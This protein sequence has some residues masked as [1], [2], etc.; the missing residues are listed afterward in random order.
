MNFDNLFS[1]FR[2]SV[3]KYATIVWLLIIPQLS[4]IIILQMV[5]IY[6][7]WDITPRSLSKVKTDVSEEHA[8]SILRVE[9]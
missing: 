8:A 2:R 1:S 5:K 6:N 7:F 9:E 3:L 4:V